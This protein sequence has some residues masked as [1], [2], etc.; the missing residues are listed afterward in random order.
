[1]RAPLL[2]LFGSL[3]LS[4][5]ALAGCTHT[6]ARTV[7]EMPLEMPAPPPRSVEPVDVETPQPVPLPEEP[8]HRAPPRRQPP[9]RPPEPKADVKPEPPKPDTPPV[10][11]PKPVE[12]PAKP[13]TLQMTPAAHEAELERS[14]RTTLV[15]ANT[16]LKRVDFG[17]LNTE[18]R[19]QYD[20]ANRYIQ[21]AEDALSKKNL[22]FAEAFAKKAADIAVQLAGK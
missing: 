13:P 20:F 4:G 17:R 18:A 2:H 14:I 19:T 9:P 1:M 15:R 7:P 6:Q 10:E 8:V 22:V 21:Q 3:T 16:D 5:V 12:E 11:A